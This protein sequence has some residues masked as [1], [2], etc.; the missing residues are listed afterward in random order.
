MKQ[1]RGLVRPSGVR[2]E[3]FLLAARPASEYTHVVGNPPFYAVVKNP[4]GASVGVCDG[5]TE[6]NGEG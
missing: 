6:G 5:V 4:R 1:L 3:D 2:H